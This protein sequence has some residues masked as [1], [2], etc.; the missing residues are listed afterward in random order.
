MSLELWLAGKPPVSWDIWRLHYMAR[1]R[2]IRR[3]HAQV[4][5]AIILQWG[6]PKFVPAPAEVFFEVCGIKAPDDDRLAPDC[7]AFRDALLC[8]HQFK[9]QYRVKRLLALAHPEGHCKEAVLSGD[10]P[11]DG[12]QFRYGFKRHPRHAQGVRILIT[13]KGVPA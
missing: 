1:N 3:L 5:V 7:K 2:A 10:A 11:E 12:Y 13:P 8:P 6:G 9:K 4:R